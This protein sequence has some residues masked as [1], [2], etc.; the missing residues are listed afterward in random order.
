[1]NKPDSI[2]CPVRYFKLT[3]KIKLPNKVFVDISNKMYFMLAWQLT[4]VIMQRM[5]NKEQDAKDS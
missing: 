5:Y 1:M 3:E 4:H 2:L